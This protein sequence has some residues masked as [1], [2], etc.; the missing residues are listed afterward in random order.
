MTK[1][2]S[3]FSQRVYELT[4]RVPKGRVTT[5]K[6]LAEALGSRAY[7][8]VGQVMRCNPYAP[9]VPCHRVVASDGTLGGFHGSKSDQ[10]LAR[11][12]RLLHAEGV[13]VVNQH[14]KDF[15]QL[16]YTF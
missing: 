10:E 7:R 6:L 15:A 9:A 1:P 3:K 14:I 4:R 5:Y 13:I 8:A 11:K 12:T 16:V 2:S